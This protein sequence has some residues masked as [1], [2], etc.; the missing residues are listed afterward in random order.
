[1]LFRSLSKTKKIEL[2][3]DK[4]YEV[5][6][7]QNEGITLKGLIALDQV[8]LAFCLDNARKL[9]ALGLPIDKLFKYDD[10]VLKKIMSHSSQLKELLRTLTPEQLNEANKS[11]KLDKVIAQPYEF[12]KALKLLTPEQILGLN[13]IPKKI[14]LNNNQSSVA[15]PGQFWASIGP[16]DFELSENNVK[17]THEKK[18]LNI[19]W[20]VS[21][22][23]QLEQLDKQLSEAPAQLVLHKW[24][25]IQ[26]EE[27]YD[28]STTVYY[29]PDIHTIILEEKDLGFLDHE[30]K[31]DPDWS[32][33][34]LGRVPLYKEI[35]FEKNVL[36]LGVSLQQ[37]KQM[38]G[39][40]SAKLDVLFKHSK[41]LK[42]F[43]QL[44]FTLQDIVKSDVTRLRYILDHLSD[45][46]SALEFVTPQV[47][48]GLQ[49]VM[50]RHRLSMFYRES[51][52]DAQSL[53]AVLEEKEQIFISPRLGPSN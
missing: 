45:V 29:S 43:Y 44:G 33:L 8:K 19:K 11:K 5:E 22:G 3:F 46:K 36:S 47:L 9:C 31:N 49:S 20:N 37:L 21:Y 42:E 16:F 39:I 41:D 23:K 26:K 48:L 27:K 24:Y 7:L 32:N 52:L 38:D 35:I 10:D 30:I 6:K 12:E 40:N 1:M 4:P 50:P 2:I 53:K 15:F 18:V 28:K 13:N 17:V 51:Q 14:E 34:V 25:C